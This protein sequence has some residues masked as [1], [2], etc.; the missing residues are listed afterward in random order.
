MENQ[1]IVSASPHIKSSLTTKRIMLDV[2]I[3]LAPATIAG[4]IF[5]G[6]KAAL[7]LAISVLTA[8][9]TEV[10]YSLAMKKPIKHILAD[11]DYTSLITGLLLGLCLSSNAPWYLPMLGSM[12]AVA[13]VKMLFGGTGKNIVNPAIAGRIFLFLSFGR[14]MTS[15]WATPFLSGSAQSLGGLEGNLTAGAT[16]L[17]QILQL[18][19]A[20]GMNNLDLFLGIG[21]AGCIGET[22]KLALLIGGIYLVIR[23]VIDWKWPVLYILSCGLMSAILYKSFDMFLPSIL[24][25]GLFLGAIFMATDY[26]T[27]PNTTWGNVIYFVLLGI[28]T[29]SLRK[30]TKLEVV[31]FV[32]LLMNLV[33]PLI[34]TYV[35]HKPFGYIKAK[36]EK[37]VK[38]EKAV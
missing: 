5:F 27:T 36:K 20:N 10:V 17:S 11:F 8:F 13:V 16:Q 25:G 21:V 2:L 6:W 18:G 30:A 24:S 35:R 1:M 7:V 38:E 33:V 19:N 34:N 4:I 15:G 29:A 32:I 22:C 37:K 23:R 26:T 9:V 31:S 12:F 28:L 14:L 3:A